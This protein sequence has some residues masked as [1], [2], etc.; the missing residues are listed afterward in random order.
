MSNFDLK[1]WSE[2]A[3][4]DAEA[5]AE[6]A[7]DLIAEAENAL[8]HQSYDRAGNFAALANAHL[9]AAALARQP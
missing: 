6:R 1:G 2:S 3:R 7:R 9:A 4:Y 5:H 8:A